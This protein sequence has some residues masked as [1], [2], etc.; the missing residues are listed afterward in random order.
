MRQS[1]FLCLAT[2]ATIMSS[3][4]VNVAATT[5]A[6]IRHADPN[7]RN[8]LHQ[9]VSGFPKTDHVQVDAIRGTVPPRGSTGWHVHL[10]P[11][12]SYLLSGTLVLQNGDGSQ[13][14]R[15]REGQANAE[16]AGVLM[17]D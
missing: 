15:I 11:Q 14:A 8:L 17:R 9:R 2:A 1:A 3:V 4:G 13:I 16:P 7:A 5:S 6:A 10:Y 12:T